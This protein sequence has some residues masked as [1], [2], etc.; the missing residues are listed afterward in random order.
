[1]SVNVKHY[2]MIGVDIGYR[3]DD[4][5]YERLEPYMELGK[6]VFCLFDGMNGEYII[7]GEI[8]Q[9]GDQYE[10]MKY[11]DISLI[12]LKVMADRVEHNLRKLFGI[13]HCRPE[14]F[15]VSH[16]Y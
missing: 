3:N 13:E 6:E 5:L 14:L 10:G 15:T 2:V 9:V 4:E 12:E 11:K 16:W 1:M 7:L 8:V